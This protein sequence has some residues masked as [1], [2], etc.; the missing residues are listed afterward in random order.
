MCISYQDADKSR[1]DPQHCSGV[2][3]VPL[4]T[5]RFSK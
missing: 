4:S 2:G 1:P 5:L 3:S